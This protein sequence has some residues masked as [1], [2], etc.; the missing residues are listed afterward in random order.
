VFAA[1]AVEAIER[2]KD[3]HDADGVM[4]GIE[5]E[6][7]QEVKAVAGSVPER[8]T[9]SVPERRTGPPIREE[10]QRVMTR[11]AGVLRS[12]ASLERAAA[13]LAAMTPT[14]VESANL[15][16]VSTV[17]VRAAT[18]RRESRGTHT[19]E[20]HPEPSSEFLGRLV[21]HGT[22]APEFVPLDSTERESSR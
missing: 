7:P 21:F 20:D 10:L 9:G 15:H 6:G 5:F 17:L 22:P 3:T 16:A 4:R 2:G 11:D 19:R 1:R 14:D 8:R 13:A 18:A 12:G